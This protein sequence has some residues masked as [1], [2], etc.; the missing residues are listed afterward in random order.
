[1][2]MSFYFLLL[3]AALMSEANAGLT[4][5]EQSHFSLRRESCVVFDI[6]NCA[7]ISLH[8]GPSGSCA[9]KAKLAR[10]C[11]KMFNCT[12]DPT[13]T[14]VNP[15][16]PPTSVNPTSPPTSVNSTSPPTSVNPTSPPTFI[17]PTSPPTSVNTISPPNFAPTS[18]SVNHHACYGVIPIAGVVVLLG[19][20]VLYYRRGRYLSLP[21]QPE[22][23]G[24]V[25]H[26]EQE[27]NDD[28]NNEEG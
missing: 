10:V 16:S 4:C 25:D 8:G 23:S 1:M 18:A 24:Q 12:I 27:V 14:S 15:T 3:L 26:Q 21:S 13:F 7:K 9:I 11:K 2:D 17:N 20:S 22:L 19:L 28:Q 5:K 6:K